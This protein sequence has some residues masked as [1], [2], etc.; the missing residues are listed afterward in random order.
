MFFNLLLQSFQKITLSTG[1]KSEIWVI[2]FSGMLEYISHRISELDGICEFG[3]YK[4][5]GETLIQ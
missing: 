2:I 4:E 3:R 1:Q 5:A